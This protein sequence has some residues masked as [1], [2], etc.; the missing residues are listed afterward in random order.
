MS[1]KVIF[2]DANVYLRF[3]DTSSPKMKLLL[4]FITEIKD[5][6]FITEQ[7]RD[8]VNRNKLQSA[9]NSFSM[10]F[11]ELGIKKSTLPEHFDENHDKR[12]AEWNKKRTNII[13]KENVL[14]REYSKIVSDILMLIM[15]STD[16]VSLELNKVF[17][18]SKPPSEEEI[19]LAR[20]RKELG[21]PPGKSGDPLGDQL[22]WQQFLS[23]YDNKEVWIITDDRDFFSK[24]EKSLY[25]NPFLYNELKN[26]IDN[27]PPEIYLFRFLSD[28]IEDFC[29][30]TGCPLETLPSKEEMKQIRIEEAEVHITPEIIRQN[31]V[32]SNIMSIGYD[33]ETLTLE[34][35]FHWGA[36]Y[37]YNKVPEEIY[38]GLLS[39]ESAGQFFHEHIK[40]TG[41]TYKKIK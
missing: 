11:K 10:N 2:I 34:V 3:Y 40:N 9:I 41:L 19:K 7:I 22:S 20:I 32:S 33:K 29:A 16:N 24:Y 26:K 38:L 14:K 18:L 12:L 4:K 21:N 27:N 30:K 28:G 13:D 6:I 23:T 35:E 39:A 36:V 31:V 5:K 37:Q 1:D 25:L 15:K 17:N 8:E